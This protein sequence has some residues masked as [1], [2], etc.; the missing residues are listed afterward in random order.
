MKQKGI[1]P[2]CEQPL[3]LNVE[4]VERDHIIPIKDGGKDTFQN[5][6]AIHKTCHD[7]KTSTQ[8]NSNLKKKK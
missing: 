7:I 2:I 3:D 1:C 8:R 4:D 6:Q 5:T